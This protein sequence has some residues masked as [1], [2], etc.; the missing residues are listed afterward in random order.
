MT[1][2]LLDRLIEYSDSDYYPFH[3]PGHKRNPECDWMKDYCKIDITEIEGFDNLHQAEGILLEAQQRAAKLYGSEETFFLVNGSTAGILS[4]VATIASGKKTL[5]MARNCHKAVYHAAFLNH[6]NIEYLYP[7]I[8]TE[9][10]IAGEITVAQIRRQLEKMQMKNGQ[11]ELKEVVAG[12]VITSPTYDG[13]SSNLAEIVKAAHEYG[14]PVIVD[15]AHGAHFGFHEAFPEG[16]IQQGADIVIHS[17]HKTLPAPTQTALLHVNDSLINREL[18][19]RYLNIYQTSSPSYVFMAAMD[20][21]IS[22][23]EQ[24]G[25]ERLEQLI[26]YRQKLQEDLQSCNHIHIAEQTE[27]GKLV[28]SVKGSNISGVQLYQRLLEQYHLQMEMAEGSYVVAIIT[29][30]DTQEGM[31]RLARALCEIDKT[32]DKKKDSDVE[33]SFY[34]A[35]SPQTICRLDEAWNE[36]YE[37]K[38]FTECYETVSADF[39]NLYPPGIPILVPGEEIN[40]SVIHT[41]KKYLQKGFRVQGID[42]ENRIKVLR[43]RG[44][45]KK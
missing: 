40:Q 5:L 32:L 34:Q 23:V 41:I 18:L 28:V 17:L 3:M 6:L 31:E 45:L 10:D 12:I 19:R 2:N 22:Y 27:P 33:I 9:Y 44:E 13:I 43:K 8:I 7:E 42:D 37:K 15:Q 11:Q 25:K 14:I 24:H 26:V 29:M 4:A 16:A 36:S 20:A 35:E 39:V 30:F 1:D 21:C 38:N